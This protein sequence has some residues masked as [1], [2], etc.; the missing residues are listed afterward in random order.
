[1]ISQKE[2][3]YIVVNELIQMF[4]L[5]I[6]DFTPDSVCH[7]LAVYRLRDVIEKPLDYCQALV[8]NW[9]HKDPRWKGLGP[10][11]HYHKGE[12]YES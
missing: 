2:A 6:K 12:K 4:D 1:M 10:V 7:L 8:S 3:T 11:C 9:V 5:N